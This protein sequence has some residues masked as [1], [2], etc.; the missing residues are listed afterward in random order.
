MTDAVI[1]STARTA[2]GRARKGTLV[3]LTAFDLAEVAVPAALE[4][5]AIPASD[6]DDLVLAEA[7]QGGGVIARHTAVRLGLT[8]VP[9]VATNRHCAGGLTAVTIAAG[10]IR[11]GMDHVVL[12]GGTESLSNQILGSKRDADGNQQI[13]MSPPNPNTPEAPAFDMPLTVGENTARHL[14]LTR[15]DVDEWTV[16]TQQQALASIDSGAFADE[17]IPIDVTRPDGTTIRFDTDEH[18]RRGTTLERLATLPVLHPE[19]PDAT[20]TAGNSAGLNDAAAAVTLTSDTYATA[21]GLT[22]LARVRSWA[23]AGIDPALT[24]L[25]PTLAIPKALDRAGLTLADIDLFEINEAFCS[26]PVAAIRTLGIKPEIVNVN[27]SGA[28]LG[29]PIAATGARMVVTMVGELRRRGA[30]L[31]CVSMC[32][33]GGMG[34]A[35]IIEVL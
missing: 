26:V 13:W 22:P 29:H 7:Y 18:P 15:H 1:V 14:G 5:S 24:G 28:S 27:G 33:G 21:H 34:A 9:G 3:G 11:A 12:A 4:R 6:V 31:G 25:A 17:I 16:Y 30:N 19:L 32:A 35:M 23:S 10:S 8:N 2:I 20:V